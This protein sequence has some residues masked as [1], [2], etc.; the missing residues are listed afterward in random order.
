MD[1]KERVKELMKNNHRLSGTSENWDEI[2]G[3]IEGPLH[4]ELP[5]RVKNWL[6]NKF[7][8]PVKK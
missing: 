3:E 6:K 7:K 1:I 8:T 5:I 2:F 4:H